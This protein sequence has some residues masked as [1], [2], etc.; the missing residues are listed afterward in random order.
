MAKK[1]ATIPDSVKEEA[2]E[3]VERFNEANNTG[4]VISFRGKFAYLSRLDNR[5]NQQTVFAKVAKLMGLKLMK[6]P[7]DTPVET[8][9]GRLA[10]EGDAWDFAPY[11]YSREKY[12]TSIETSLFMPGA[13]LLDGTIEGAMRAGLEFYP[14]R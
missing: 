2:L 1:T 8:I 5:K 7:S 9:I 3:E 6:A 11:L 4:Y 13:K 10:W 12:D 14:M